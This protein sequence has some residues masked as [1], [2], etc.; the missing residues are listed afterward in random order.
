MPWRA[1]PLAALT[2]LEFS[3]VSKF[4]RLVLLLL[5]LAAVRL[6]A[7]E[8]TST[9]DT[10]RGDRLLAD[11]FRAE[12][13]KLAADSLADVHSLEDW[14]SRREQYRQQL[15]EMLGLDPFP[16]RTDLQAVVTGTVE[17]DEFRVEKLHFQSMPRL[18]VT[19]NL[20][21]PKD[22]DGPAPTILYV[23]GHGRVKKG[24][25]SYGNKVNYQHHPAWFARH[26]YVCLAID[27]LQLGE[28][29]GL[30]HGTYREGMWWWNAYGYTPAGVE[31]WNCLRALDYLESRDEVDA[32]RIGVTGRSGGGAYSWW[33][34]AIDERI[35]AAVPVAGITDL[36][37]HVVD[38]VVEG[39]CDCMFMVNTQRWDYDQVAALVA[40]RPLLL[41]NSDSDSI[42]PLDGV[43]RIHQSLRKIYA[44]YGEEKNLGLVITPGPHSDTQELQVPAFRWFNRHLKGDEPLIEAAAVEF[45][46]PEELRV[47]DE[48]P[49]DER[50]TS[51]QESFTTLAE[52]PQLPDSAKA[53]EA[54]R[55]A[56][57]AALDRKSFG[58]WPTAADPLGVSPTFDAQ[59]DGVRLA[60]FDFLSQQHVPLRLYVLSRP[61][62][63][64]A[65]LVVL[66]CLDAQGWTDWLASMRVAFEGELADEA[67]PPADEE[68]FA[69][70]A[71]MLQS[72]NWIM[73]YVAPRGIGPTAWD[74]SERKQVQNRRRFML[75]G[76]TLDGMRVW[77]V[78][79]T[80]QAL[81]TLPTLAE[82]PLWLQAERQ[83]AG[84]ALYASLYEPDIV[85]LDLWRMP[86]SHR[87]GPTFL[88][89]MRF[90]DLPQAVAMAAER[91]RVRIYAESTDGWEY[92]RDVADTL[93]W[94]ADRIELRPIA[95]A[96]D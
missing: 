41:A 61:D 21:V 65:E 14:Q 1:D 85:R 50:N 94:G 87:D 34:A 31:A 76:Q 67:L 88:N 77:D 81:R 91:C 55:A 30:H 54:Q 49:D 38:G 8:E 53:W 17:H 68:A 6:S 66:N 74:S 4:S 43:Y 78:R 13:E 32:R 93:G 83:M 22:L 95:A 44:L 82:R 51:I 60:G 46:E 69:Q 45:F 72:F 48:N 20:Y 59:H 80:I 28:I 64:D 90:L 7:A 5:L 89:V 42:F 10:S 33:I 40:P 23:C 47:F 3:A 73:A 92:P 37:N 24:D 75:L 96:G 12:T 36:H 16:P 56:W 58:G 57:R 63:D 39:H 11:Y 15:L 19:G 52:T 9:P 29:E 86:V 35:A 26:G 79:R 27:T 18:Y 84:V 70:T 71:Q 2:L 25:I 62:R